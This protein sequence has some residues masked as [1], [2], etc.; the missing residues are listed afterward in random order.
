MNNACLCLHVTTQR[1]KPEY[2][3]DIRFIFFIDC[4]KMRCFTDSEYFL[5]REQAVTFVRF[6]F[7]ITSTETKRCIAITRTAAIYQAVE[8]FTGAYY[9][10]SRQNTCCY[11]AEKLVFS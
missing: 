4:E 3:Y 11:F 6:N 5:P 1:N 8:A 9:L 2:R 10:C 7:R